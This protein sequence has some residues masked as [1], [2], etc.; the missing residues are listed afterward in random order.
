M[1]I[2]G[3]VGLSNEKVKEGASGDF[4]LALSYLK[5]SEREAHFVIHV[6]SNSFD[7]SPL[8]QRS[9]VR[10]TDQ[11]K[12]FLERLGFTYSESCNVLGRRC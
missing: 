10:G 12:N 3:H 1:R 4:S 8:F 7:Y 9:N 6:Y 5:A 11:R 2:D